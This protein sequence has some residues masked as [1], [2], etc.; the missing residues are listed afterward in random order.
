MEE[1]RIVNSSQSLQV[2][3]HRR[4]QAV[5]DLVH[6]CPELQL[7]SRSSAGDFAT[8]ILTVSPPV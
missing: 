7:V 2:G 5:V 4:R 8:R 3:G 1:L 6:R